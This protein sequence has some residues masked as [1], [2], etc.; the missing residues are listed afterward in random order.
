MK[1]K[2]EAIIA[3]LDKL[4]INNIENI[5]HNPTYDQLFE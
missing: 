1:N 4:G 3:S 2:N 5:I